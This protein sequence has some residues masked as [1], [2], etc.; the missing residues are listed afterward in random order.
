MGGRTGMMDHPLFYKM[1]KIKQAVAYQFAAGSLGSS[2]RHVVSLEQR[3]APF[4]APME[5]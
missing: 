2:S 4:D 5:R 1:E 3:I